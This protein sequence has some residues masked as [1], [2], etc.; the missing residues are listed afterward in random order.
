[1]KAKMLVNITTDDTC[2]KGD[3]VEVKYLYDG[4]YLLLNKVG[5]DTPIEYQAYAEQLEILKE[6]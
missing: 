3:I 5:C 1:M 4:K 2:R 6:K